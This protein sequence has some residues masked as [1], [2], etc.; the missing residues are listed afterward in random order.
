[1]QNNIWFTMQ[2]TEFQV[3]IDLTKER[4]F[5]PYYLVSISIAY[6]HV[7]EVRIENKNRLWQRIVSNISIEQVKKTLKV[8]IIVFL[9]S[10]IVTFLKTGKIYYFDIRIKIDIAMILSSQ[11][12]IVLFKIEQPTSYTVGKNYWKIFVMGGFQWF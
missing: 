6:Y 9:N 3:V 2:L 7:F 5:S 1:M 10:P 11:T 12:Q 8:P 4:L